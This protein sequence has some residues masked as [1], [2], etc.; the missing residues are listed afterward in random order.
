MTFYGLK[1]WNKEAKFFLKQK[2]FP[3]N[4]NNLSFLWIFFFLQF[5]LAIYFTYG[6]VSS[7]LLSIYLTLSSPLPSGL[8]LKS[9]LFDLKKNLWMLHNYYYIVFQFFIILSLKLSMTAYPNPAGR[10]LSKGKCPNNS[11]LDCYS[12]F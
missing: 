8:L 3:N 5:P 1:T 4:H 9:I 11:S 12:K 7:M 6:N 10:L 2:K